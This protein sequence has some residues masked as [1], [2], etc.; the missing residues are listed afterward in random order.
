M[1]PDV[2]VLGSGE[3]AEAL[4]GSGLIL[5]RR[6]LAHR[7]ARRRAA[8]ESLWR[9][10]SPVLPPGRRPGQVPEPP[11][12]WLVPVIWEGLHTLRLHLPT[13]LHAQALLDCRYRRTADA[14][15]L[16]AEAAEILVALKAHARGLLPRAGSTPSGTEPDAAGA[17]ADTEIIRLVRLS[18]AIRS[19]CAARLAARAGGPVVTRPRTTAQ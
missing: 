7:D 2:V 16:V 9:R 19:P 15:V 12:C 17:V 10:L 1:M 5:L 3:A 11:V 13:Q 6:W 14:A 8:L 4:A 18:E